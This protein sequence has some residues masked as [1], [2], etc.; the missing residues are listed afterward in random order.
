MNLILNSPSARWNSAESL[1]K[2]R[3]AAAT[4]MTVEVEPVT[5]KTVLPPGATAHDYVSQGP[6]WWPDPKKPDGLPYIR[7][8][9][10]HNPDCLT[11]S[12]RPRLDLL[13]NTVCTLAAARVRL[14]DTQAAAR[15][16]SLLKMFFL[17]EATRMDPNLNFGQGIPGICTGRCIGVIETRFLAEK[18]VDAIIILHSTGD[19]PDAEYEGLRAWFSAFLD[20]LTTSKIGAAE[21]REH[22]NHSTSYDLQVAIF[23]AFTGHDDLARKT[24]GEVLTRR[25]A[26]Q[27]EPDGRQPHELARTRSL[28]YT[29]MN[30]GLF[31]NL[32]AV[33]KRFD[34]D[35]WN[36]TT[37]DGRSI[38]KAAEWLRP[39]IDGEKEWK[40]QQITPFD[41][42][43][44]R[45]VVEEP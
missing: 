24:L 19:L 31:R 8:D 44:M 18:L 35:L 5:A 17:D 39:Y 33:A 41:P 29:T 42:I 11:N 22:N 9:G 45:W 21:G 43:V 20:W 28:S 25:V 4:A 2:L 26:T 1:D 15:A 10:E 38:A 32:A 3:E 34:I 13:V 30:M 23:A 6:Y 12:D 16:A 14:D 27:I 36:A 37:P 40:R 7:R